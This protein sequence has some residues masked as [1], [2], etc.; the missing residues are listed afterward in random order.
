MAWTLH[1]VSITDGIY[2][3]LL[4]GP[5]QPPRLE[6]SLGGQVLGTLTPSETDGGW[7]VEG[8]LG[9]APLTDGAQ[10]VLIR[11]A[12]GDV[13]DSFTV[14]CGLGAPEDLRAELGALR[15]EVA[16]LKQAFRRHVSKTS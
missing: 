12:G 10:T 11:E 4:T 16:I 13:L 1:R 7:Q 5:G 2:R 9:T 3:G 14:L 15:D 6:M 8:P